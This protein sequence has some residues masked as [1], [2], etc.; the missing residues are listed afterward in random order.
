MFGTHTA[1]IFQGPLAVAATYTP[2]GGDPIALRVIP[3]AADQVSRFGGGSFV[4]EAGVFLAPV[5]ALAAPAAGDTL[6][7]TGLGNFVVQGDPV[8][9]NR[10][11]WWQFEARPA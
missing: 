3:R 11:L 2:A 7:V 8:R 9:D 4:R 10:R 6:A 5:A 1:A